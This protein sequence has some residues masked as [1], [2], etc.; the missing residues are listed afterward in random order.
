MIDIFP[1]ESDREAIRVELF[2][3]EIEELSYFDPLTGEV[4]RKVPRITIFPKSHYVTPQETLDNATVSI[5]HELEIRL[6]N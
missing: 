4:T 5:G 3:E 6:E 2:D 1:A